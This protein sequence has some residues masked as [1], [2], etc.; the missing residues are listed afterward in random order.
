MRKAKEN[1]CRKQSLWLSYTQDNK[2][3]KWTKYYYI[4]H[5]SHKVNLKFLKNKLNIYI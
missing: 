3:I 2:Y 5:V 1:Q 4:F